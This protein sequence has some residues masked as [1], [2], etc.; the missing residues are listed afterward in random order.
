MPRVGG[1]ERAQKFRHATVCLLRKPRKN[2]TET[3]TVRYSAR[4]VILGAKLR[5]LSEC[6][7]CTTHFGLKSHGLCHVWTR[8]GPARHLTFHDFIRNFAKKESS[9]PC[10]VVTDISTRRLRILS[11]QNHHL[12]STTSTA[13]ST[14]V[15]W[16][17]SSRLH[18]PTMPSQLPSSFASAA[19]G[20]TRDSRTGGRG[21]PARGSGSGEW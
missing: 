6:A 16:L 18:S 5:L 2:W 19:A 7:Q 20:Q 3:R 21:E 11:L 1:V 8:V 4:C 13:F 17:S 9:C 10:N 15:N 12:N 14:V